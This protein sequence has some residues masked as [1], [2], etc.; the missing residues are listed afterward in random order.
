ML[1]I[2]N[3]KAMENIKLTKL[4]YQGNVVAKDRMTFK[5]KE[6]C[7]KEEYALEKNSYKNVDGVS[8]ILTSSGVF[9][10]LMFSCENTQALSSVQYFISA[11]IMVSKG[12]T[13][14]FLIS[15]YTGRPA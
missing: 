8:S 7:S 10:F 2:E 5:Q 9:A 4:E 1:V 6:C 13:L 14:D 15:L 3:D 12:L 11:P